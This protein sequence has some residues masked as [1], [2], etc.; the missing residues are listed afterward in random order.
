[1]LEASSRHEDARS[2]QFPAKRFEVGPLV[3]E[4]MVDLVGIEATTSSWAS[5]QSLTVYV[6]VYLLRSGCSRPLIELNRV[7]VGIFY[8]IGSLN[9]A[10]GRIA[11]RCHAL[12]HLA[13]IRNDNGDT[14]ELCAAGF[15]L[16]FANNDQRV[17]AEVAGHTQKILNRF[18]LGGNLRIY[19]QAEHFG[20]ELLRA[21]Q[22]TDPNAEA[23]DSDRFYIVR[24][25]SNG[26]N[27]CLSRSSNSEIT[28]KQGR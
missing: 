26:C 8:E 19:F 22:I 1:M 17:R 7:S 23:C 16:A 27:R 12:C 24:H 18:A 11:S 21:L 3:V 20:I 4:R 15:D 5:V 25:G 28:R 6:F 9:N 2:S 10:G 14:A 13:C